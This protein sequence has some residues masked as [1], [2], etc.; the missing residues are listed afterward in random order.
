MRPHRRAVLP[1]R[2]MG[3]PAATRARASGSRSSRASV[4]LHEGTLHASSSPGEGTVMTV[5]LPINGPETKVEETQAVTPPSSGPGPAANAQMARRK[6]KSSM[7]AATLCAP[8]FAGRRRRIGP[9]RPGGAL[10]HSAL[11]ALALTTSAIAALVTTAMAGSNALYGQRHEHPAP[12]F[13][14]PS[15]R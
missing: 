6:K 4:E 8:A 5:L 9:G 14:P 10:G 12:L 15:S 1:G 7:T 13:A 3:S 11:H 2:R